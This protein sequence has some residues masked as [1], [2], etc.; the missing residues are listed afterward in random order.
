MSAK[1]V[2][3]VKEN[4]KLAKLMTY[5]EWVNLMKAACIFNK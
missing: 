1:Y 2:Q 5:E 4:P 3:W